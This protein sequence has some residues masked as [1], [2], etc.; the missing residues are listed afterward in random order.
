M[1]TPKMAMQAGVEKNA[2]TTATRGSSE[3]AGARNKRNRHAEM[4]PEARVLN[5]R[6][7]RIVQHFTVSEQTVERAR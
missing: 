3:P 6:L 4:E 1:N 5:V 2:G 7:S